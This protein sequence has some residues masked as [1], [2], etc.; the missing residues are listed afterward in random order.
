M[1]EKD[2]LGGEAAPRNLGD[3]HSAK[4]YAS[5]GERRYNDLS[6]GHS[7]LEPVLSDSESGTNKLKNHCFGASLGV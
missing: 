2:I 5:N 7:A 3:T 6:M 1:E 4:N